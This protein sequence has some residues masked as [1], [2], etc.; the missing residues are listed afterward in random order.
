MKKEIQREI[1][2][3]IFIKKS[4][5][6]LELCDKFNLSESSCRRELS[7]LDNLGIIKRYHGGA[8][9]IETVHENKGINDRFSINEFE[10]EII[11][12]QA[13]DLIK[14]NSTIIMLGG[15]TVFRMCK[16]I[17]NMNLTIITNSM[18]VFQELCNRKNIHLILLGGEYKKDEA[19]LTGVLTITNSKIFVCSHLFMGIAGYIKNT[20]FTTTD[21]SSIE[22]YSWCIA[23]S[24]QINIL[25]DS[26]KFEKKGKAITAY[27]SDVDYVLTDSKM[28]TV[29]KKELEDKG[30]CVL[31]A[32][33]S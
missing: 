29:T 20:G 17:Q 19:E 32:K 16:H 14:P 10:K 23:M 31:I 25:C 21:M 4:V 18:I 8:I 30:I 1:Q 22:L 13:V 3:F 9:C 15:T 24:N 11:A 12:K 28:N 2:E 7:R 5:T 6:T 33:E 26:S 27:L